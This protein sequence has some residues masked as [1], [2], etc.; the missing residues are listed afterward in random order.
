[1]IHRLSGTM[2]RHLLN[3]SAVLLLA[4]GLALGFRFL[5]TGPSPAPAAETTAGRR[6]AGARPAAAPAPAPALIRKLVDPS[7]HLQEQRDAVRALPSD[8]TAGEFAALLDLLRQPPPASMAPSRW[9]VLLNEIMDVLRQPR[10]GCSGYGEAMAGLLT[11]REVD[12]VVR[13]YAAQYLAVWLGEDSGPHSS[14]SFAEGMDAFL[15]VLRGERE[16]REPVT[17]TILM[18][19]CA[20]R[21]KRGDEPF[22]PFRGEIESAVLAYASG[23]RPATLANRISAIQAAGRMRFASALPAIRAFAA[24]KATDPSVRLSSVAALGYFRDPADLP[25]LRQLAESDDPLRFAARQALRNH[26]R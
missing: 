12:P 6:A 5:R 13:D 18:S 19:L 3:L 10:F 11:D 9:H 1:M 22:E 8:L 26:S 4:G 15:Q 16:S 25:F 2:N 7:L 20:L 24:G 14:E 23:A 21:D 17:G